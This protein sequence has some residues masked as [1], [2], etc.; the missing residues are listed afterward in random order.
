VCRINGGYRVEE[1]AIH[2]LLDESIEDIVDNVYEVSEKAIN[3]ASG[4]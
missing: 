2:G 1:V 3:C 4:G